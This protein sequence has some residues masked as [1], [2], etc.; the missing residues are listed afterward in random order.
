M[1]PE[2]P[3][4]LRLVRLDRAESARAEAVRRAGGDAEEGTLVLVERPE[5]PR[6]RLGREWL[7]T[8][9]P[10][11]HAALVLRPGLPVRDCVQLAPATAVALGRTFGSFTQPMA[12]LHYRWPNDVLLDGGKV[13]GIWLDAGGSRER[14]DWLVI[15]WSINTRQS[16]ES[17][18][19]AAASLAR[20]GASE[21]IDHDELL[22]AISRRLVTT[23]TTWDESGFAPILQS[24]RGRTPL[25]GEVGITLADG[26]AVHGTALEI[27][28]EG[29]L[30][31]ETA[32]RRESVTLDRF[33]EPTGTSHE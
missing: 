16:P 12:E 17:L 5:E 33:F 4:G 19:F 23:I 24:W 21:R 7:L 32:G 6:A 25:G 26:T 11:L 2:L 22:Q 31:V 3:A 27:D 13:A 8:S 15:S 1:E 9:E 29:A 30:V 10:G 28:D 20:E 18:G 14:L